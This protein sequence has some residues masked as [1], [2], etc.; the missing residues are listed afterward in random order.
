MSIETTVFS[1][2]PSH[3]D[4]PDSDKE[5]T[6]PT[7]T[8]ASQSDSTGTKPSSSRKDNSVSY[9]GSSDAFVKSHN[10]KQPA[11]SLFTPVA[12]LFSTKM[13]STSASTSLSL[14][15][16]ATANSN[17]VERTSQPP[18]ASL[19]NLRSVKVQPGLYPILKTGT[20]FTE[21]MF[22]VPSPVPSKTISWEGSNEQL[23]WENVENSKQSSPARV[24]ILSTA[25]LPLVENVT[26]IANSNGSPY[27][28]PT[29]CI[30]LPSFTPVTPLSPQNNPAFA[31]I[32]N[33][34]PGG[35]HSTSAPA[36]NNITGILKTPTDTNSGSNRFN[37]TIP[38]NAIDSASFANNVN[39]SS[40]HSLRNMRTNLSDAKACNGSRRFSDFI[41]SHGRD[42]QNGDKT[43]VLLANIKNMQSPSFDLSDNRSVSFQSDQ[44]SHVFNKFKA[45]FEGT[46]RP[47]SVKLHDEENSTM[48]NASNK[49]S[50]IH[51]QLLLSYK[52]PVWFLYIAS[53]QQ[54]DLR[55]SGPPSDEGAGGG[56]RTRDRRVPADLRADSL[57]LQTSAIA[58]RNLSRLF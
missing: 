48:T 51:F 41:G 39:S 6:V 1:T 49:V 53:L 5:N 44:T 55:L 58:N 28:S 10:S 26:R 18:K 38:S 16:N 34:R 4:L 35:D 37:Y 45:L 47:P 15:P 56:S 22:Q 30:D 14:Q 3:G 31:S 20:N 7:L 8:S 25:S 21:T 43:P 42:L 13:D 23:H 46:E 9:F 11:E 50:Q 19:L 2:L 32:E 57:K 29:N 54:V 33:G 36:K 27:V 17:H 12:A 52:L 40:T 24:S